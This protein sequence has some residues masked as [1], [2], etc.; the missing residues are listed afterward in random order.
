MIL[1][2]DVGNTNVV[3]GCIEDG[4]ILNVFRFQTEPGRTDMEYAIK[5][6]Q[7][8]ELYSIDEKGFEGA[9]SKQ[10]KKVN[11]IKK[12][13]SSVGRNDL[14]PCGSGKKYKKCCGAPADSGSAD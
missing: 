8:L 5:I 13:N 4:K 10:P 7:V 3:V 6:K 12:A 9:V 1:A 11:V 2:L 14:C